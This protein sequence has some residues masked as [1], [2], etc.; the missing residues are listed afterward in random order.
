MALTA[1]FAEDRK[2]QPLRPLRRIMP[3]VLRYPALVVAACISLTVAAATTLTL[4]L[5]APAKAEWFAALPPLAKLFLSNGV[6]IAVTLGIALN[7]V[8]SLALRRQAR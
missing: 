7:A 6:V 2:R 5:A 4:P 3:Y 8:L 1:T